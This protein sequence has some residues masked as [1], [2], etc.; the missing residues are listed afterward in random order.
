[1][2]D[3]IAVSLAVLLLAVVAIAPPLNAEAYTLGEAN[4]ALS[5]GK[6]SLSLAADGPV[7]Y[8]VFRLED[9]HRVVLDLF[10][11]E[12]VLAP[13]L[14]GEDPS[15]WVVDVRH[16]LWKDEP[17]E[18]IVRYVLTTAD[19][20]TFDVTTDGGTL[21]LCVERTDEQGTPGPAPEA[22]ESALPNETIDPV[23]EPVIPPA[24]E[25]LDQAPPMGKIDPSYEIA[26][27]PLASSPTDPERGGAPM[28]LDVQGADIRTVLRSI[29]EFG[30]V[31]I[32]PDRDVSGPI[33]VRL[34]EVPWRH[35][36]DLVCSSAGLEAV[37]Q[38]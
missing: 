29:A 11:V 26:A 1:M 7:R 36:L 10:D 37:G 6:A 15:G 13:A 3:R 5:E 38:G 30:H 24:N 4:C 34:V 14:A 33:S 2:R 18:R 31:N 23:A 22:A 25:I 8:D 17:G 32:V 21:Q 9:P 12:S 28:S 35:A 27:V 19:A 16:S 20:A